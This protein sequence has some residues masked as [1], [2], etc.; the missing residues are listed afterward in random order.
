MSR[1]QGS[2][3]QTSAAIMPR[4]K[5]ENTYRL[6][7]E[8]GQRF[9]VG[10]AKKIINEVLEENLKDM[11]YDPATAKD[12][13]KDMAK[14]LNSRI[15][16]LH[17]PRYKTV[18]NVILGQCQDQGLEIASRAL[19]YTHTDAWTHSEYRNNSVFALGVVHA[20]YYE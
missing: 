14:E 17:T 3:E 6:L 19:W 8:T 12:L 4:I 2:S 16:Q 5:L 10:D 9:P 11:E 13:I 18:C 1:F 15:K 20:L 7:P